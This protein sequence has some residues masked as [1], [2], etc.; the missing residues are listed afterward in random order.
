M[1]T[2]PLRS[3]VLAAAVLAA[4]ALAACAPQDEPTVA[5]TSA[6]P[7]A[8]T[9]DKLATLAAGKLTIGTD[10]PVYPPWF[11]DNKPESGQGF[12]SA[13]AYAIAAKLGY[14]KDQVV[15]TRVTFN[16][17]IA[18]GKKTYDFDVNEFSITEDRKKAVDFSSPYYDV[19]QTVITVK[20]SKIAGA[21]SL[22]DLK[23]AKLGA[24][25]GTTSYRA[26]TEVIKPT[27]QPAVF[28]NN[29]DAKKQLQNG[30]VDGIVVDLPT[31]FYITSAELDNGIIVGQVAQP[32]GTPEQFGLVLD[33]G[34][35]LTGCVSQAVDALRADGTLAAIEKQWL[36]GVAG[37]PTLS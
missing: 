11:A 7:S 10:D 21:K 30:T 6:A 13:V 33:K 12:E 2:P 15:W 9:P 37:A 25:V 34:S 5:A 23:G 14:A 18:P 29:D 19:T 1:R 20:G 16:N 28:N 4:A 8:C 27:A 35:A 3:A 32:A 17:A 36:A 22:A 24:Q 31:A 26:I